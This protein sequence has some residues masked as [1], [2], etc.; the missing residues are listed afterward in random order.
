[1]R[2]SACLQR[3]LVVSDPLR[4]ERMDIFFSRQL[5]SWVNEGGACMKPAVTSSLKV[6]VIEDDAMIA[7]LYAD[8]LSELG[9]QVCGVASTEDEAV[10]LARQCQ[11]DIVI[12]DLG[13]REG[14]GMMAMSRILRER[15]VPH[16][17][18]TGSDIHPG[19]TK[20]PDNML[21]KPFNEQQLVHAI[22]R[23][24]A[25]MGAAPAL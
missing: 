3:W 23:A 2:D 8:V 18:I 19:K 21:R 14:S 10:E 6:L 12:S 17:F 11:P 15:K 24:I 22:D 5:E 9:H 7:M 1:M 16:V 25:K 20:D 13:L 4:P